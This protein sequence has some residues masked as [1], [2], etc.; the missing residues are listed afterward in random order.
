M[1]DR[2]I[3]ESDGIVCWKCGASLAGVL[4]PIGRRETCASCT[5][6]LH[7]CRQCEYHDPSV[8]RACREPVADEVT[9]KEHAN[10]C[11]YFAPGRDR[12][13]A[14]D[15]T[16]SEQARRA[17]D[18]LFGAGETPPGTVDPLAEARAAFEARR[19]GEGD[20]ARREL[21]RLFGLGEDEKK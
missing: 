16:A 6:D 5:A 4:L 2:K 19:D 3:T 11:G 7:V 12:H 18:A 1:S 9:R 10:F 13:H 17:L 20:A 8:A 14:G 21:E 15:T